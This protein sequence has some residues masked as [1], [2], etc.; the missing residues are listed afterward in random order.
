MRSGLRTVTGAVVSGLALLVAAQPA[1]GASHRLPAKSKPALVAHAERP[2]SDSSASGECLGRVGQRRGGCDEAEITVTVTT[3]GSPGGGNSGGSGSSGTTGDSGGGSLAPRADCRWVL[4]PEGSAGSRSDSN[5]RII[6][7]R[8]HARWIW[9]CAG[10]PD[11]YQWIPVGEDPNDN[12][13]PP[14]PQDLV[15][16]LVDQAR[17]TITQ[18]EVHTPAT[19][20]DPNGFAYVQTPTFFWLPEEQWAPI[21]VTASLEDVSA[22]VSATVTATPTRL[23]IDPGDHT[24]LFECLGPIPAYAPGLPS[25]NFPGCKHVYTH[26]SALADTPGAW[27]VTI[28]LVWDVAWSGSTGV[29]GTLAELTTTSTLDLPVAE[30]QA[31]VVGDS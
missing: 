19:E 18:P 22:T 31:I 6:D 2:G 21:S 29:G 27:P 10:L 7:G 3:G 13:P 30:I 8:P 14:N 15:P 12:P 16:G 24:A 9:R 26:S 17:R 1:A 28:T 23:Q 5:V 4:P 11:D 25:E 20:W